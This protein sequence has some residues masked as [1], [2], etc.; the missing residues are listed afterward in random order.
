[1]NQYIIPI[2]SLLI[3]FSGWGKVLYDLVTSRPKI[4]GRV[5]QVIQGQ[6]ADPNK[7]GGTLAAFI[8]YLYLVNKRRNTIHVL[9]YEMEIKVG[10][11]WIRLSRVYGIQ[12]ITNSF[13]SSMGGKI[14]I[15]NFE[16]NLIYMK[17]KPVE[18]G[19]P[20]HGW[21]VFVGPEN[22]YNNKIIGA[23][24]LTCIDAFQEKH[25]IF[26][27]PSDFASVYLLEDI[28]EIKTPNNSV[29]GKE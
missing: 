3:G 25:C 21:I 12:N 11:K 13:G 9:D 1:M 7:K 4:R 27:K 8:T 14:D 19:E 17:N 5:F 6:M 15:K 24:K 29:Y 28:A 10:R 23:F 22:L 16:K 26:T 20:L 2:L 18:Y